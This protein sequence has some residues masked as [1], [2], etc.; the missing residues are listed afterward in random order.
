MITEMLNPQAL[1]FNRYTAKESFGHEQVAKRI[2]NIRLT[3]PFTDN[4]GMCIKTKLQTCSISR[5]IENYLDRSEE[6]KNNVIT[7]IKKL[8]K[9]DMQ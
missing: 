9:D 8:I 3:I 6:K 2:A 5:I 1:F 4:Y 7:L